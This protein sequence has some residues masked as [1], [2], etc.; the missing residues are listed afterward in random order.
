MLTEN[1]VVEAICSYLLDN[2]C[3]INQKLS[4]SQTGIDIIATKLNGIKCYIEVKGATSSKPNTSK[5]GKE[6]D[7]SQVKTHVGVALVASFRAMNEFPNSESIIALP[8]N[9]NH[10]LIIESMRKPIIQSGIKVWFVS[11][12]G[13][14]QEYI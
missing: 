7:K 12:K 8:N 1:E 3:E 2:Q 13:D 14:V 10:R 11:E 9:A 4:T 5:F 6:F